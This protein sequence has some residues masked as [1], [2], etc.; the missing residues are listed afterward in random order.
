MRIRQIV[1]DTAEVER[2]ATFWSELL[3][4]P[5]E[6]WSDE[7]ISMSDGTARL[8]IQYAP[9]HQPPSWGDPAR[10]QQAHLDIEVDDIDVAEEQV[11]ASGGTKLGAQ[12][13]AVAGF[14]VYADPAGHP[15]CLEYHND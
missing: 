14:R 2:V 8:A 10:P 1:L 5:M 3:G 4:W 7:W 9:D 12:D 15:F 6:R 13:G 11:L